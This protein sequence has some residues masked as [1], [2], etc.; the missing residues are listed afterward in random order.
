MRLAREHRAAHG[1]RRRD[2]RFMREAPI[3][4]R[5]RRCSHVQRPRY[6]ARS[7]SCCRVSSSPA[8]ASSARSGS[9]KRRVLSR[10]SRR[11]RAA[12]PRSSRSTRRRSGAHERRRGEGLPTPRDHLTRGRAAAHG[13]LLGDGARRGAHGARGRGARRRAQ[14][15][16]P[17][18]RRRPRHDDGR[19]RRP[20]PISSTTWIVA[21]PAGR[22]PRARSRK[23]GSTL[24]P[25][26]VARAIGAAGHGAHAAGRVRRRQLRHRLRG[27]PHPRR[28]RRRRRHGRRRAAPGAPVQRLRAPRGDGA[29]EVP[30]VRPE[31]PGPPPRRGR[32]PAR[33]RERG[34][35]RRGAARALQA[36][37]GGYGLS[38]DA[39]HITRPHPDAAGSI[40]RDAPAPSSARASR[41]T[42]STSSTRTAPARKHNDV[43]E[44]KVMRDVFGDR[45]VPISSMK[46][47]LGHCMGAASALE[48]IGCVF[49]LETGIYPPTIGYETPD[50]EC[51]LDVVANVAAARAR[52][53]SSSTT[54]SRSAATTRSP[55]FARPGVLPP[56]AARPRAASAVTPR[57]DH[58]RR[59][60]LA[61]SASGAR[62]VLRGAAATRR[63]RAA[64]RRAFDASTYPD[65]PSPR[66]PAS[67]PTKYLGDKGLRTL[68]RLTKL[69]VV[70]ARLALHDAG[71]RRTA[72]GSALAP[73]RVGHRAART[74]TARSRRSPSSIASPTLEDARYI[75]PSRSS[76]T[77]SSNSAAGYASI[78]EDLRALNVSVSDGNCGALDAVACADIYPRAAGAPTRSSSGGAR[79][80]ERG[81]L[82]RVPEARASLGPSEARRL[83]EGAALLALEPPELARGARRDGARRG[84][85]LRHGVRRRPSATA[86]LVHASREALE[87]GDRRRAR[88][89]GR[90]RRATSTSSS[91]GVSGLRA[92]D[93]AELVGDRARRSGE[94]RC[95]VAP[96]LALGETLG[97]GGAHGRWLAAHRL[98]RRGA[99]PPRYVGARRRFAP[100]P[101]TALVTSLGLL[102]QRLGARHARAFAL[103]DRLLQRRAAMALREME[104]ARVSWIDEKAHAELARVREAREKQVYP[105]FREFE[106]GGL[107]T[108]HRR[109]ADHQLQLER[110]PRPDQPPEGEGGG[111]ARRR[112]VRA[113]ASRARARRR[114]RPSTSSSSSA[115]RSGSAS[116]SAC[117]FTTGYQA[118]LGTIV[119]ARRQGHDARP[120]RVQPRLH[121]RRHVPRG[122]RPRARAR[123][124][125]LQPQLGQEPRAHPEDARAQERARRSSRAST[126]S[127][128]TRRTS[129]SSSRSA[130][131]TTRS[132]V[133][134]D[135]HG[136]GTLGDARPRHPRGDGP[137]GQG[138]DR[139]LD[140]LEDVRR[141]RRRSSS[142]ASEVVEHIKHNARS[143]LFS[144]SLPVPD[145]RRRVAPSSTCSRATARS[146]SR[147]LHQKARLLPRQA[148]R[149]RL[150]SRR[151]QHAHHAGHVPRGAQDALHARRAARVRRADG[152]AHLSVGEARRGAPARERHARP[153]AGGH[154]HGARAPQD[155]RRGVLRPLGRGH[156]AA[157]GLTEGRPAAWPPYQPAAEHHSPATH[158][159]PPA[160]PPTWRRPP[161]SRRRRHEPE[162]NAPRCQ[163]A[164]DHATSRSTRVA[165]LERVRDARL[166]PTPSSCPRSPELFD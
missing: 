27:G 43:A 26:H 33:A 18:H 140:V 136:T 134:D 37:V 56:P 38:C 118:M 63:R 143:F 141:H 50:P 94:R 95:V 150:R 81:A 35:R 59:R 73:E 70:A 21:R 164:A 138:A 55:C 62:G 61:R 93:D 23:Y 97:A 156:R 41:P 158:Q 4:A 159:S 82:P 78:W 5:G 1:S 60:R 157:R 16:G 92:F 161:P 100:Q 153:H 7:A 130:S 34:A 17:A 45:R 3:R 31:P 91:P 8:S 52:P 113:A 107:H 120:R 88:R 83:G 25:I 53:T 166:R 117:T 48:A 125:L 6:I 32:G 123:G 162:R 132:L 111:Q 10:R 133:V 109:Q 148:R 74:P 98:L 86:S 154:G 36:E 9:G 68:D 104:H 146:S 110:L 139:R 14:L 87:R 66:C 40:A 57:A 51:D 2:V 121:P 58:R 22:A 115:S 163:H 124:P 145:R 76:R 13:P 12:S 84:H 116:R 142:A 71:S 147:E 105:Y 42:T 64:D 69:L 15:A 20:R 85:R 155:V 99:A 44:A 46:S 29:R 75:N 127:T 131:A 49:T 90:S 119:V 72:R 108:T 89:R 67:T 79:G 103:E 149:D 144:A 102:R 11:A 24:L 114:R 160:L 96:K 77:R 112:Q 30:A 128:A 137:R 106:T 122:G 65:A 19:G 101:R 80:D 151:E 126:R 135:A 129:P 47:M 39:Y 28:A 54:R 152:A 165:A